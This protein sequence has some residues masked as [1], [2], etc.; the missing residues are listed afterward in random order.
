[1]IKGIVNLQKASPTFS[2]KQKPALQHQVDAADLTIS[3]F[4]RA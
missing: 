4:A 2:A 3:D 1:M